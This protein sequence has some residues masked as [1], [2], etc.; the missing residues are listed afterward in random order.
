MYPLTAEVLASHERSTEW[1]EGT[2]L[3]ERDKF[4]GEFEAL[5]T[6]ETLPA[7]LPEAVG[8]KVA[9]NV[10]LCPAAKL[11]GEESPLMENPVPVTLLPK[12]LMSAG[13]ELVRVAE[14]EL[15]PFTA[16]FPKSI[17]AGL[18]VSWEVT[19]P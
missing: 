8:A 11:L 4:V 19:V 7:T 9:V 1:E 13:P 6:T 18:T 14:R 17:E 2:L 10:V 15:L 5:L 3:P 16:I 12:I